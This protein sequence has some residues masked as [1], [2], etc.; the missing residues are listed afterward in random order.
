MGGYQRVIELVAV[1]GFYSMVA[2][3]LNAFES[4]PA[5]DQHALPRVVTS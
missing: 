5:R 2:L 1:V 4:T 3:T